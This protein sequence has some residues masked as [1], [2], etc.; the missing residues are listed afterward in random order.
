MLLLVLTLKV[1]FG[2]GVYDQSSLT[3]HGE[4]TRPL[5]TCKTDR[6]GRDTLDSAIINTHRAN[7]TV[8]RSDVLNN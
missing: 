7:K 4:R 2:G 5:F 1:F 6:S 8:T 3:L